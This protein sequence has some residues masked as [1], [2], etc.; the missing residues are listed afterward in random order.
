ML[1]IAYKCSLI[2]SRLNKHVLISF[3]TYVNK[4]EIIVSPSVIKIHVFKF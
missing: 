2:P 1:R 3:S 4:V